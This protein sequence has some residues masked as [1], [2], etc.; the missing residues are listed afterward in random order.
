MGCDPDAVLH[1]KSRLG[2]GGRDKLRS[3]VLSFADGA[4]VEEGES[5]V[6]AH[7]PRQSPMAQRSKE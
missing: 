2:A 4:A 3:L 6:G 1:Y 7:V 5:R